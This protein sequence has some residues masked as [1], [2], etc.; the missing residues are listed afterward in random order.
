MNCCELQDTQIFYAK[1]IYQRLK[2]LDREP[3]SIMSEHLKSLR[4]MSEHDK[5]LR[6]MFTNREGRCTFGVGRVLA[7]V[8]S[9]GF[10][11]CV[12]QTVETHVRQCFEHLLAYGA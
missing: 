12:Y 8:A 6:S 2:K 11:V 1:D 10:E 4:S 5:G 7:L 9:E 3:F